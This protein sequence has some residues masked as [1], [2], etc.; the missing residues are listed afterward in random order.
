MESCDIDQFALR[1][2]ID[3]NVLESKENKND[4]GKIESNCKMKLTPF[5]PIYC[6]W[7]M[8]STDSLD[9]A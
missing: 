8:A 5:L 1:D 6:Q 4:Q 9:D 2:W 3:D 7:Y